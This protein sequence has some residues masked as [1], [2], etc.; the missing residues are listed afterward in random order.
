MEG[1]KID[2]QRDLFLTDFARAILKDRYL[3][4]DEDSAQEALARAALAFADDAEHANRIYNYASRQW[5]MYATPVL[6]NAPVRSSWGV[7]WASNFNIQHYSSKLSGM[8]ISCF[9]NYV[10]DSRGGLGDHYVE[11]IW[12]ASMGGGIGGYWGHVRSDGASTSTGSES[13]GSI[14]FMH[15][16]DS[17][18]LAF[19]QGKTRRGSYS[20]YTDVSHPEVMEVLDMRN[21]TGGD[22]NRKCL[23][24]HLGIVIPDSFMELLVKL[25][26]DPLQ[27]PG[28]DLIDPN[29]GDVVETIDARLLVQKIIETRAKAGEPYI[30]W[31]DTVNDALPDTQKD[32]G[33]KVLQS[34]LCSE[35]TLPTSED[36]TAV[37]C[38]SSINLDKWDESSQ[39]PMF[40]PDLIRFLDNVIEFFIQ[41]AP[42]SMY[43]ATYSASQERSI[44]LG[45]MG[46]HS[47]LQQKNVP[48][49]SAMAISHNKR[50]Y[51]QIK[52]EA[53]VASLQLGQERG[54]APDMKGTGRRNA[55][56]LAIAP[57]ATSGIIAG[58]SPSI[59]MNRANAF[60]Q[61]TMSGSFLVKNKYLQKVLE[62]AYHELA[63]H[64][65]D[66]GFEFPDASDW[67]DNV[68]KIIVTSEG[69]V[70]GL[71]FLTEWE[72]LV[73]KTAPEANQAWLID[74]AADRQEDICQSQS[75][76]LFYPP[77][78]SVT[79]LYN[80][81]MR[82]WKKKVK[83]LYYHR[84]S[85]IRR[86]EVVSSSVDRVKLDAPV[87]DEECLACE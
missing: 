26:K 74:L 47:Y 83:T 60:T 9:L 28:W 87:D 4:P 61:K 65:H 82:A 8:P 57:N 10:P 59:E 27:D 1:V 64:A 2:Y 81:F 6:S 54:E 43:K 14:P 24:L 46:F 15:V 17:Q 20:A 13:S 34:N 33:L 73:Y 63:D 44:G 58:S 11:N 77:D 45:T 49:E 50:I 29:S 31:G 3:M 75:L 19:N 84:S 21:P 16:V 32:L 25:E 85:A 12:L 71:D 62:R 66:I 68:W 37:C 55:H 7:D 78:V 23:N 69:S 48:I 70:D 72:K 22:V 67:M 79:V 80:H 86:A 53:V 56:L 36:R 52:K 38:L 35:I 40:I 30:M 51:S 39:D 41:N 5:F 76:N 18:M 42:P